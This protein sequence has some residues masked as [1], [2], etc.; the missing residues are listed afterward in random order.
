MAVVGECNLAD[1]TIQTPA[2]GYVKMLHM[3]F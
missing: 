3:L 1:T 2:M